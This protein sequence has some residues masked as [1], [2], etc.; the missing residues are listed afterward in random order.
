LRW[1]NFHTFRHTWATWMRQYG[2][3]DVEGLVATGN[4]RDAR[5]ARRY[6]HV[7]ARDEWRRVEALPPTEPRVLQIRALVLGGAMDWLAGND[8]TTNHILGFPAGMRRLP[9]RL[10]HHPHLTH[11]ARAGNT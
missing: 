3:A 5:S 10:F 11:P 4:W 7:V 8:A 9:A 1:V 6:A 2:G